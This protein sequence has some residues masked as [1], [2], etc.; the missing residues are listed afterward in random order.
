MQKFVPPWD[1]IKTSTNFNLE[2]VT[3]RLNSVGEDYY[4]ILTCLTS[5]LERPPLKIIIFFFIYLPHLL[6]DPTT[7]TAQHQGRFRHLKSHD[8]FLLP[9][10]WTQ[11]CKLVNGCQ[12]PRRSCSWSETSNI[13]WSQNAKRADVRHVTSDDRDAGS[14]PQL[15]QN[16]DDVIHTVNVG[17]LGW[18]HSKSH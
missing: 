7:R 12:Y 5:P 10:C 17:V 14:V 4:K 16:W 9:C 13:W 15:L 6:P 11:R 8:T 1:K 3:K 18:T 2:R